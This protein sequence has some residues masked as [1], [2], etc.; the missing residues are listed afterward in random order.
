MVTIRRLERVAHHWKRPPRR[1]AE[2]ISTLPRRA[3]RNSAARINGVTAYQMPKVRSPLGTLPSLR[4]LREVICW[5]CSYREM[6]HAGP[7]AHSCGLS[8]DGK[9][10]F[11]T[12]VVEDACRGID[13][14]GSLA[15]AWADMANAG[16]K[17]ITSADIAGGLLRPACGE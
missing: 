1:M 2:S 14:Q 4:S 7:K 10:G 15:K 5:L 16:V 12:Y 3:R 9:A 11:E 6:Q 13:T 17:R 8:H